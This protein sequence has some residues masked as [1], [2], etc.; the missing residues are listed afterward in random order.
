MLYIIATPIGNLKDITYRAIET[1][2]MVDLVAAEDTRRTGKLLA[3]Y[4]IKKKLTPYHEHN[5]ISKTKHLINLLENNQNIALVSDCGTP[6][7]SDPGFYL[8][9]ECRRRNI[10][11]SPIPGPSAFLAA[12]STA[13]F[14]T[15]QF[16]F[17][18]FLSKKKQKRE[19]TLKNLQTNCTNI[20]Y[21]SPHRIEKTLKLINQIL[22]TWH[23]CIA[24]ELTKKHE[25]FTMGTAQELINKKKIYKGEIVI[26]LHSQEIAL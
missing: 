10:S 12:L 24:R 26:L 18:G 8:I 13:G 17:F 6:T 15:D 9:R 16:H 1:L 3:H 5:K 20:F 2:E 19:D 21:E 7:I 23:L 11:V 14:E 4:N 22:P 25:E